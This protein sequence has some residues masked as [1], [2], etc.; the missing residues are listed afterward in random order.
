MILRNSE[1]GTSFALS[2]F[3]FLFID[4]I[5]IL[6]YNILNKINKEK[7]Y[8]KSSSVFINVCDA[9]WRDAC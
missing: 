7:F 8:E 9:C 3:S 1:R 2:P 6:C 4:R 5:F